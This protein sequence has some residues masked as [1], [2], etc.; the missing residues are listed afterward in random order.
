MYNLK[1]LYLHIYKTV[2][3][4]K[5]FSKNNR[6]TK[7][8]VKRAQKQTFCKIHSFRFYTARI[9]KKYRQEDNYFVLTGNN[10]KPLD[11]RTYQKSIL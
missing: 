4:T 2:Y 9:F 6:K 1:M 10:E 3:R 8:I 5:D 11:P 7:L